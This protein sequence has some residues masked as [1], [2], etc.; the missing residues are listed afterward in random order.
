MP[1]SALAAVRLGAIIPL[2][3]CLASLRLARTPISRRM[4]STCT[5]TQV[6]K[7]VDADWQW[8][9]AVKYLSE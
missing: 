9:T 7:R 2:K 3:M 6:I 8:M 5:N 1:L 4:P